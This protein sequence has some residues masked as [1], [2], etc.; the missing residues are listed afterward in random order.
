MDGAAAGSEVCIL[1]VLRIA[2]RYNN[3]DCLEDGYGI[4]LRPLYS[5][6]TE[7]Y[8][9]DPCERFIPKSFEEV[10]VARIDPEIG[11]KMQKMIAVMEVK[12]EGQLYER[13]P[14]FKMEDRNVLKKVN[15][16]K[17]VFIEN[18]KEYKLLDTNFL[19]IDPKDPLKLSPEESALMSALTVSFASS[20]KLQRHIDYLYRVGSMFRII[21][22][23]LLYHGCIPMDSN[24]ELDKVSLGNK[25]LKGRDLMRYIYHQ[26]RDAWYLPKNS[27]GR[28]KALDLMW[29][30]WCGAKSPLFG[31]EKWRL[32]KGLS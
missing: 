4:N 25:D 10:Q 14:D 2:L 16:E 23:N 21:N 9:D 18:G 17:G 30:L 27:P 15:F 20:P 26:V 1:A 31:K 3:F 32:L 5:Y 28:K 6:A 29:Y 19:T 12:L 8:G 7:I 24:G 22:N 13:N 11:A